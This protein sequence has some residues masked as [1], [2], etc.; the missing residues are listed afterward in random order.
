MIDYTDIPGFFNVWQRDIY[1]K[2][3]TGANPGFR[4]VEVG[5]YKGRSTV[6]AAQLIQSL[7][8]V[9]DI[10]FITVDN[11]VGVKPGGD[12]GV[13]KEFWENI[14]S[15]VPA[16]I[17]RVL[18][19]DSVAAADI[20]ANDSLDFVFIDGSHPYC[21]VYDDIL[22]WSDKLVSGGL[23]AGDDYTK[24]GIRQA[25]DEL[26]IP[27]YLHGRCWMNKEVDL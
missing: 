19:M 3:I 10:D 24:P 27:V 5:A 14:Q 13:A 17:V 25:V 11:F 23:L 4:M 26:I 7:N 12:E 6:F 21:D 15:A 20:T 1:T 16:G 8:K 22:A 2:M 9:A 18:E